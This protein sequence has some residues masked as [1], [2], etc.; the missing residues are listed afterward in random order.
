[1]TSAIVCPLASPSAQSMALIN[2]KTS[3]IKKNDCKKDIV[4]RLRASCCHRILNRAN[5]VV[6]LCVRH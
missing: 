1:M 2:Q 4:F 5:G 6:A 3:K